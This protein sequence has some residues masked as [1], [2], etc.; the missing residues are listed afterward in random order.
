MRSKYGYVLFLKTNKFRYVTF[1]S[2]GDSKAFD[3]V[4]ALS[5]YGVGRSS[6]KEDCVNH[7]AKRMGTALRNLVESC[8]AHKRSISGKG[9]LTKEKITKIQN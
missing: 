5:L 2:D 7:V 6:Q 1:L 9:K 8:K 3:A 4:N